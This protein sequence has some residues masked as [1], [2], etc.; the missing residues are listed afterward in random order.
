MQVTVA[1]DAELVRSKLVETHEVIHIVP[2]RCTILCILYYSI[3]LAS[4]GIFVG[5]MP[6]FLAVYRK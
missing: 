5:T 6:I 2:S 3:T 1:S 4:I